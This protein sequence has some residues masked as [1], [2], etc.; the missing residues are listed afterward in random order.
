MWNRVRAWAARLYPIALLL[1]I[2]FVCGV[3]GDRAAAIRQVNATSQRWY[4]ALDVDRLAVQSGKYRTMA[5]WLD[6]AAE[7]A[8]RSANLVY[9]LLI[10]GCVAYLLFAPEKLHFRLSVLGGI[11]LATCLQALFYPIY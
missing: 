2:V 7:A 10:A 8:W 11:M 4:E 1:G 5:N 9:L 6:G 3:L